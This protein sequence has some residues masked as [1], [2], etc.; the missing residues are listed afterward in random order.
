MTESNFDTDD[1]SHMDSIIHE[2]GTILTKEKQEAIAKKESQWIFLMRMLVLVVL[3]C[4][5]IAVIVFTYLYMSQEEQEEFEDRFDSDSAKVIE[6]IGKTMDQT[7]GSLD[8]FV[9]D[10]IAHARSTNQSWPFVTIPFLPVKCGKVMK[11]TKIFGCFANIFVNPEQMDEWQRFVSENL[12]WIE[13]GKAVQA[14]DPEWI[15]PSDFDLNVSYE[16]FGYLGAVNH[17]QPTEYFNNFA[18]VWQQYPIT[19]WLAT[20][21]DDL[22]DPAYGLPV[23]DAVENRRV[24]MIPS[25]NV[26]RDPDDEAN[27]ATA[28][29]WKGWA[30]QYIGPGDDPSEPISSI[31]YPMYDTLESIYT[32]PEECEMPVGMMQVTVFF[33][34]TIRDILPSDSQGIIVV[35]SSTTKCSATFT[36]RIDGPM[37]TYLGSGDHHDPAY[38]G[39]RKYVTL[40]EIMKT[41]KESGEG[42]TYTGLPLADSYC[43]NTIE[44]YPSKEME[45]KYMTSD[46]LV[47]TIVAA[48]IFLFT[49]LVFILYDCI[50]SRRQR[51]VMQRALASGA[52]VSSLFPENVKKQLYE[53]R[54]EEQ[55]KEQRLK[56]FAN[57]AGA[58]RASL[59]SFTQGNDFGTVLAKSSKPIAD[60]FD[61]TTVFFADLAGFTSWSAKRTP[62][63]V[64]E[65]LETIY[66][67]F[68][69]VAVRRNVFKVET[70]GDCYVAVTGIPQPQRNHATIMVRFAQECMT[71][72]NQLTV[73]LASTLG[74]DTKDLQMRVGLHSGST[75]A[76]VLRG[77]KGRFQLFGDTVNT[78]SRMESN[79]VKGRIHVSQATA[80]AITA[81]GKGR[82]LTA[83][84]DKI[85][86]KGKGEMQTYFVGI[87]A[88]S[89]RTGIQSMRSSDQMSSFKDEGG[90]EHVAARDFQDP[91]EISL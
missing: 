15:H 31:L 77:D 39:F 9:T 80:D 78:A 52:I 64:F 5:A 34:D 25:F 35:F 2:N 40:N 65:L 50:V 47:F 13:E 79:G 59:I 16:V 7:L 85:V 57:P 18:P 55:K 61:N 3:V 17:S 28:T 83:R 48:C 63:E 33:K 14:K 51:I 91:S 73:E 76:G 23:V 45:D 62:V 69:K 38:D 67:A 60:L 86:A 81:A 66:G 19:P 82:W 56:T 49:S 54:E 11:L 12:E 88:G 24:G 89:T 74:D 10:A 21:W 4:S 68:D 58:G 87:V 29:F 71:E 75:T 84:E 41:T 8:G 72:M 32:E 46:P 1:H 22:Q 53:E 20:N 30:E 43:V 44:V 42:T 27:V 36:Y 70:V 26:V 90:D 6:A 37:T